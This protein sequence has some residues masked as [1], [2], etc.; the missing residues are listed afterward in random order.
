M[1][2]NLL[3]CGSSTAICLLDT[4]CVDYWRLHI[5]SQLTKSCA[6]S[7]ESLF[8]AGR[9]LGRF[10]QNFQSKWPFWTVNP[11]LQDE[12]VRNFHT[13]LIARTHGMQGAKRW[14]WVND[15]WATK[16]RPV[17]IQGSQMGRLTTMNRWM[18]RR[19]ERSRARCERTGATK[20]DKPSITPKTKSATD[21]DRLD[22]SNQ[23]RVWTTATDYFKRLAI[24]DV[25]ASLLAF[26]GLS[27]SSLL[28][29][30]FKPKFNR[31]PT[32]ISVALR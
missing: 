7:T 29:S 25:G 21:K 31:R 8:V 10:L 15:Q 14:D 22:R 17:V 13:L 4:S 23:V 24:K 18:K 9:K 30:G 6:S 3:T 27:K 28:N 26:L 2:E 5:E 12:S 1:F 19:I 32:S 16:R 11:A 20:N